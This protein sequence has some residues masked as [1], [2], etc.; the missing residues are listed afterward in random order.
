M[1]GDGRLRLD[2]Y[3]VPLSRS[4]LLRIA[5]RE[6][7]APIGQPGKRVVCPASTWDAA[8]AMHVQSAAATRYLI[9][10]GPFL[11]KDEAM[12]E[13]VDYELVAITACKVWLNWSGDEPPTMEL[14][15]GRQGTPA[16]VSP[17]Q[18]KMAEMRRIHE[19]K[20]SPRLELAAPLR[21]CPQHPI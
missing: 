21:G 9:G 6:R 5:P 1:V 13:L 19:T 12:R 15:G 7:D 3:Y 2:V 18:K 8:M 11:G 10:D 4:V 20:G 14:P 16:P 17:V